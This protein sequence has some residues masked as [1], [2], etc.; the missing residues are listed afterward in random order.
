MLL[1]TTVA[2]ALAILM[3][4]TTAMAQDKPDSARFDRYEQLIDCYLEFMHAKGVQPEK[5]EDGAR[6]WDAAA[7]RQ[8]GKEYAAYRQLAGAREAR[9]AWREL[10]QE[11]A[12]RD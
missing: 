3:A 11:L 9:A 8:C 4:Q 1:R 7:K 2:A 10:R 12:S 6:R 5:D